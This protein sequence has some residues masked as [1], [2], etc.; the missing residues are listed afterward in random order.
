VEH[1][2]P[3]GVASAVTRFMLGSVATIPVVLIGGFFA[4]RDVAIQEAERDIRER[5]LVEGRLAETAL[6]DGILEREAA[7]WAE[8]H[9]VGRTP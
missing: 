3:P 8:R 6:T 4:L 5:V 9:G 7:L 1:P 2:S